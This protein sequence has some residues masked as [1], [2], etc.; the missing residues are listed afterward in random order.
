MRENPIFENTLLLDPATEYRAIVE[1]QGLND[2]GVI[3]ESKV[4]KYY[5][6]GIMT[7]AEILNGNNRKYHLK[8][9]IEQC[10]K[11]Q[12]IIKQGRAVGQFM[13]TMDTVI[14]EDKIALRIDEYKQDRNRPNNFI[15]KAFV[16]DGPVGEF[17]RALMRAGIKFGTS[18]RVGGKILQKENVGIV[19]NW[20]MITPCEI[21]WH[22]SAPDA[23]PT[24]LME[25]IY[26][27]MLD[28]KA[29]MESIMGKTVQ[30][31]YDNIRKANKNNIEKEIKKA[32]TKL[33]NMYK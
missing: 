27:E 11:Y 15:G 29:V 14:H 1:K 10:G 5:I 24:Q 8:D 17:P 19:V 4:K 25:Q 32:F 30:L 33:M 2:I 12:P 20:R 18:S 26:G 3:V 31:G 9:M 13:H 7:Q 23:I 22:N 28:S 6:E 21:V 16:I